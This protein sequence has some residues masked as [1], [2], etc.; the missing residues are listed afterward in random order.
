VP[1]KQVPGALMLSPAQSVWAN[2]LSAHCGQGFVTLVL[3]V[4]KRLAPR[5]T[6]RGRVIP[7]RVA[8]IGTVDVAFALR[9]GVAVMELPIHQA[10]MGI[11]R[12][13]CV[14]HSTYLV[15][16]DVAA[17]KGRWRLHC[18]FPD[19]YAVLIVRCVIACVSCG[20]AVGKACNAA[21]IQLAGRSQR[22]D[23]VLNA[24][25]WAGDRYGDRGDDCIH[26]RGMGVA[27]EFEVVPA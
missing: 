22:N 18:S 3:R 5:C 20:D 12:D 4:P 7:A 19:K 2:P 17:A 21:S 13:V 23:N 8:C 9:I 1:A 24:L 27:Y 10:H 11:L 25:V 15:P 26:R 14:K 16:S 6:A